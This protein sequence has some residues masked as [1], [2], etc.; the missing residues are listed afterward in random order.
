MPLIASLQRIRSG[1][2]AK[3]ARKISNE[4][5]LGSK[6]RASSNCSVNP[7]W[8]YISKSQVETVCF[9]ATKLQLA[10]L[11]MTVYSSPIQKS[12]VVVWKIFVALLR[13]IR[14]TAPLAGLR[15]G[16]ASGFRASKS[17][18]SEKVYFFPNPRVPLT[19][20]GINPRARWSSI[21][22]V[23]PITVSWRNSRWRRETN[24]KKLTKDKRKP[25]KKQ[26][27]SNDPEFS[28]CA[29]QI[30]SKVT[31]HKWGAAC[32]IDIPQLEAAASTTCTRTP[33]KTCISSAMLT[34]C[35]IFHLWSQGT[36]RR[37]PAWASALR[38]KHVYR[39]ALPSLRIVLKKKMSKKG[40][41]GLHCYTSGLPHS[42]QTTCRNELRPQLERLLQG[43]SD[44]LPSRSQL[45]TFQLWNLYLP[46][47]PLRLIL[48]N[49]RPNEQIL[50][51]IDFI[52]IHG[53]KVCW[54]L[55]CLKAHPLD[56]TAA[57]TM[58][59]HINHRASDAVI[60]IRILSERLLVGCSEEQIW[61]METASHSVPT[62]RG[63]QACLL[64]GFPIAL[65]HCH[66]CLQLQEQMPR[67]NPS[68]KAEARESRYQNLEHCRN[69][70]QRGEK[71]VAQVAQPTKWY[72]MFTRNL[73]QNQR[74]LARMQILW[75]LGK[76]RY[77]VPPNCPSLQL[78]CHQIRYAAPIPKQSGN[79]RMQAIVE[80]HPVPMFRTQSL[81]SSCLDPLA[82]VWQIARFQL[83][84]NYSTERTAPRLA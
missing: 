72:K 11:Q 22:A 34:K 54:L 83:A 14:S 46:A 21:M 28:N 40:Q 79:L 38:L 80:P 67:K 39:K 82:F 49:E 24:W 4:P 12:W 77:S 78:L 26:G 53:L 27:V 66:L 9:E 3:T 5:S 59:L 35:A 55:G 74:N 6:G 73:A 33:S 13:N 50:L 57:I 29:F 32:W 63:H 64:A 19:S 84:R 20:W 51:Q 75:R 58:S 61:K 43:Q 69:R 17:N 10:Q 8:I 7:S 68:A 52:F 76:P 60:C 70:Y 16:V 31:L 23:A 71:S 62:R 37:V 45:Q 18:P 25:L 56:L 81:F 42:I 65:N 15:A 36:I 30:W 2:R 44:G 1:A 48:H 41:E 47:W